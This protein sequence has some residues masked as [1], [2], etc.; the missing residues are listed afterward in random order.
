MLC[1]APVAFATKV[2]IKGIYYVALVLRTTEE[3][4]AWEAGGRAGCKGISGASWQW[5]VWALS[6]WHR[7]PVRAHRGWEGF[8]SLKHSRCD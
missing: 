6:A 2:G 7:V 1:G 8:N 3:A 5:R 4:S